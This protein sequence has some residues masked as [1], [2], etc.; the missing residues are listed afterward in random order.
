MAKTIQEMAK[1]YCIG[2]S[3]EDACMEKPA[4]IAGANAVLKE[5]VRFMEDCPSVNFKSFQ[6]ISDKIKQLKGE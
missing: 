3:F 4:Y 5:L 6:A 2:S 1:E